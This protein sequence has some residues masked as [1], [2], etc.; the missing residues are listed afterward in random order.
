MMINKKNNNHNNNNNALTTNT[1]P[2][3]LIYTNIQIK[4]NFI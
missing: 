2:F 4:I 3:I 1:L